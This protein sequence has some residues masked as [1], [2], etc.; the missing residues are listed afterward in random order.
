VSLNERTGTPS[1]ST[2]TLVPGPGCQIW[3]PMLANNSD[4]WTATLNLHNETNVPLDVRT[5]LRPLGGGAPID[6]IISL[7]ARA[8]KQI[9]PA[10]LGAPDGFVGTMVANACPNVQQFLSPGGNSQ[11]TSGEL[12][13]VVTLEKAGASPLLVPTMNYE[14]EAIPGFNPYLDGAYRVFLPL[15]YNDADG[16]NSKV[17]LQNTNP[18]LDASVRVTYRSPDSAPVQQQV[19]VPSEAAVTLDLSN[20]PRGVLAVEIE[21][22]GSQAIPVCASYW[23]TC[24]LVAASYHFGPGGLAM[25]NGAVVQGAK[26]IF[27]PELYRQVQGYDSTLRVQ[28]VQLPIVFLDALAPL[29]GLALSGNRLTFC[30][31]TQ[32]PTLAA[33][34]KI[35][36]MD[37]SGAVVGVVNSSSVLFE[38]QAMSLPLSSLSFLEDGKTYSAIVEVDDPDLITALATHVNPT[39]RSATISAGNAQPATEP[40]RRRVRELTAP[41][42]F[43][44]ADGITSVLQI[45]NITDFDTVTT[46]RFRNAFGTLVTTKTVTVPSNKAVM[47]SA[48]D[49]PGLPAGFWGTAEIIG[50]TAALSA[51]VVSVRPGG[52]PTGMLATGATT[53]QGPAQ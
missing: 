2:F 51:N 16:W 35:T 52:S 26:K 29:P 5:R 37:A 8:T 27:F 47:I 3:S 14:Q 31:G 9:T 25:A 12:S 30:C 6:R 19:V 40:E 49:V 36:F 10:D 53:A 33:E 34:P 42:V 46:V 43:Q 28:A 22:T 39:L 17:I 24:T 44:A 18:D 32:A 48:E 20:A 11:L 21:Q 41:I 4:G 1:F 7:V 45:Q 50:M 15:V 38:G 23:A 13:G